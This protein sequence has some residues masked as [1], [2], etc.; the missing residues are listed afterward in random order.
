MANKKQEKV[1]IN[2]ERFNAVKKLRESSFRK[3]DQ[4]YSDIERSAKTIQR[5]LHSGEI[6]PELLDKI[7][8]YWDIDPDY[9]SG[10]YDKVIDMIDDPDLR[11]FLKEKL[12]KPEKFPYLMVQMRQQEFYDRYFE[13]ILTIHGILGQQFSSLSPEQQKQLRLDMETAITHV[14]S[15]FFTEDAKGQKGL[16]DLEYLY[17]LIDNYDPDE[18]EQ[19]DDVYVDMDDNDPFEDK[20]S[21]F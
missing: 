10:K 12:L 8:R 18:P 11:T 14:I 19:F 4:A 9:L 20:Y 3:L 5:Q 13:S 1:P 2:L 7:S 21:L 16:P 17:A 15:R 6:S